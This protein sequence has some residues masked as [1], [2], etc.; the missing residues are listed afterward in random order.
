MS[1]PVSVNRYQEETQ[2]HR[3]EYDSGVVVC[4]VASRTPGHRRIRL[5][6]GVGMRVVKWSAERS[7]KPPI[8]P[9]HAD[10]INDTLLSST[11]NAQLPIPQ[12][13]SGTYLFRMSGE[14]V[15]VQTSPR[16][17][18]TNAIP[19]GLHPFPVEPMDGMA[20]QMIGSALAQYGTINDLA[21]F[22]SAMQAVANKISNSGATDYVWPITVIP[23]IFS[24]PI[25]AG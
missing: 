12:P 15:F 1:F 5:H 25:I 11:V 4:P 17:L 22:D 18:G 3:Y 9:S 24:A 13:Q 19:T 2:H 8:V 20:E 16:L 23:T 6:G 7:G 14:Y 10:T 21:T